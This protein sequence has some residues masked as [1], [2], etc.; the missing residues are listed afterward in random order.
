MTR[1]RKSAGFREARASAS[2]INPSLAAVGAVLVGRPRRGGSVP[3]GGCFF[4]F[5]GAGMVS[6]VFGGLVLVAMV[7]GVRCAVYGVGSVRGCRG[8][9]AAVMH[10]LDA[11]SSATRYLVRVDVISD[12]ILTFFSSS[13][14]VQP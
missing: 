12:C 2:V 3:R 9:C 8:F 5:F 11:T 6:G 1:K 10:V 14:L 4:F 13:S 7:I